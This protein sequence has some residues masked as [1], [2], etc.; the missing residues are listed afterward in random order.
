MSGTMSQADLVADL[1]ASLRDAAGIFTAAGDADFI[2]HLNA[3]ALALNCGK[4]RVSTALLTLIADQAAYDLPAG[5]GELGYDTW[6]QRRKQPWETGY[7]G[8]LP[9]LMVADVSGVK[10]LILDPAPSQANIDDAGASFTYFYHQAHLIA[11]DAANTTVPAIQRA[12]LILRAQ[13]EAL[14]ELAMR[15]ITKPVQMI[16]G[17]G[18]QPRNGTPSALYEAL[19][20]E[21]EG[22]TA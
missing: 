5:F 9:R 10:K 7:S 15:N 6:G 16:D 13:V 1:K 19:L 4:P 21:F 2:R 14:R 8:R 3:A 17:H 12:L 18:N 22:A 20:R 11:T